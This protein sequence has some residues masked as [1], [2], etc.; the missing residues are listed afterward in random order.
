M[1]TRKRHAHGAYSR[2][3]LAL[4]RAL[5]EL[6]IVL[7][8]PLVIAGFF[9]ETV[10]I[11]VAMGLGMSEPLPL[12]SVTGSF[13]IYLAVFQS[14]IIYYVWRQIQHEDSMAKVMTEAFETDGK[15][16]EQKVDEYKAICE[17]EQSDD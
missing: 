1:G 9:L 3:V 15:P 14:P 6:F 7:K 8:W 16:I 13:I 4:K 5:E 12:I 11:L 17:R 2:V 10:C